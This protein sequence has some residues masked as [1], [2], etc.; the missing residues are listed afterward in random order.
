[1]ADDTRYA[2]AVARVRGMETRLLDRQWLE[3]LLSESA[4]GTLKA[5]SDSAYQEAVAEVA[6]PE[7]LE[8]GLVVAL[9]EMFA[10]V[11]A[12]TPEPELIG[13]FRLRWDVRNLKSL[14]KAAFLKESAEGVGVVRGVGTIDAD[15]LEKWVAERD[16]MMLPDFLKEAAR[17]AE[18]VYRDHSRLTAVDEILDAALA[19]HSLSVA[20]A[21]G[22]DF[23]VDYF[24]VEI[25][26]ENVKM[27]IRM[28]EAGADR[29]DLAAAYLPGGTLE[30][31]F[32]EPLLGEPADALARALEY[33]RYGALAPVFREWSRE[34]AHTLELACDN[35]LLKA[36]DKA[37]M[38]AYGIE[39]LVA[40]ILVRQLE[41]KLL[42][43]VVIAKLN[44][45]ERGE[46]EGRLRSKHV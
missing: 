46:V 13:L 12:I 32:F 3:R 30:L 15:D 21:Y 17:S 6:R 42:R 25:D 43:T 41:I 7:E 44:G 33:G 28:K 8:A 18:E 5:L 14:L 45:I 27:F 35:V 2:Y 19:N 26:L 24:Q 11:S 20:R 4:S 37:T 38:I 1:M 16:Y 10:E 36:V 40:F 29:A 23:L 9:G 22:N 39:P 31:S 34:K